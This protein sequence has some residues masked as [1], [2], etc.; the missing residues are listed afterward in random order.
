MTSTP[1]RLVGA[2]KGPRLGCGGARGTGCPPRARPAPR[3]AARVQGS[4]RRCPP[5]PARVARAGAGHNGPAGSA[6]GPRPGCGKGKRNG[7]RAEGEGGRRGPAAARAGGEARG[8]GARLPHR[9]P[10]KDARG[11]PAEPCPVGWAPE[12]EEVAGSLL[13]AAGRRHH[14]GG[15]VP[16]SAPRGEEPPPRR[17]PRHRPRT[18][19][20]AP[21]ARACPTRGGGGAE[22]PWAPREGG[23]A[24]KEKVG[25]GS[26]SFYRVGGAPVRAGARVTGRAGSRGPGPAGGALRRA[27]LAGSLPAPRPGLSRSASPSSSRPPAR[28]LAR[29]RSLD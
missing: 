29:S 24:A 13:G 18:T 8:R 10:N 7:E 20:A 26:V 27:A 14:G 19:A 1:K 6:D 21:R 11:T 17:G 12:Q 5:T 23:D 2:E 16:Q 28:S 25:F 9:R 3:G 4:A 22:K 15:G